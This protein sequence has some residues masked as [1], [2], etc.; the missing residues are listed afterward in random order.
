MNCASHNHIAINYLGW[1]H[2]NATWAAP[3]RPA[4]LFT[5][6]TP[7][8]AQSLT[9]TLGRSCLFLGVVPLALIAC[10]FFPSFDNIWDDAFCCFPENA[11]VHLSLREA[12]FI[13]SR[14]EG[15]P[16]FTA[17][18]RL[19]GSLMVWETRQPFALPTYITVCLSVREV[20][21]CTPKPVVL[22]G[23]IC[24]AFF[25]RSVISADLRTYS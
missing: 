19:N 2:S 25:I 16:M 14:R 8:F 15:P 7:N 9:T 3:C 18:P 13:I 6:Q 23:F 10:F 17:T 22:P 1:Q 11:A 4:Q 12:A 5:H 24:W 20:Q 21:R